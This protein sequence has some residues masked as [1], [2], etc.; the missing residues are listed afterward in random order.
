LARFT[1]L[2]IDVS[3][4]CLLFVVNMARFGNVKADEFKCVFPIV[5]SGE[6]DNTILKLFAQKKT[7]TEYYTKQYTLSWYNII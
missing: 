1:S 2:K 7:T 4:V 3:A 5:F 6:E